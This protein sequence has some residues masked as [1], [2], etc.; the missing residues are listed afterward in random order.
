MELPSRVA[1][2]AQ[3]YDAETGG[4]LAPDPGL[5]FRLRADRIEKIR[6]NAKRTYFDPVE[7][8]VAEF[9]MA[10]AKMI[11][12]KYILETG[13][14][15]GFSTCYLATAAASNFPDGKVVTID[16]RICPH[17]WSGSN[18]KKHISWIRGKSQNSMAKVDKIMGDNMFDLLFLD[19]LHSYQ[20]LL[21]E[22]MLFEQ[23]LKTGGLIVLHD[24]QFYDGL[25]HVVK[26]V[27]SNPRYEC[28]NLPTPRT[29]GKPGNRSPGLTIFRLISHDAANHPLEF[30]E[31]LLAEF[32]NREIVCGTGRNLASP[33]IIDS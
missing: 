2:F 20:N 9:L 28:V 26:T 21:G 27:Q 19:S 10:L 3:L 32:G 8:E 17:L 11:S 4:Y 25:G 12:A 15:R 6:A 16:P 13:T 22:I 29:H 14:S 23:K 18:L 33:P 24:T 5:P 7:L 31:E 1:L 30:D